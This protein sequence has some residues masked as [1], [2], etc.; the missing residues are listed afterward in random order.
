[1]QAWILELGIGEQESVD[2]PAGR[3]ALISSQRLFG[4][5]NRNQVQ[6]QRV[7]GGGEL[8]LDARQEP[9]E[10]RVGLELLGLAR[11]HEAD[12][13]GPRLGQ[14]TRR[15]ARMPAQLLG[16]LENAGA[17]LLA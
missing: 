4:T 5:R 9:H 12:R 3:E 1:M 7:V 17:S 16:G 11:E 13:A 6:Q 10:E 14:G 2:A 15:C 8:A